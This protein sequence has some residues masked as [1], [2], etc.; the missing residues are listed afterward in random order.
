L[1]EYRREVAPARWATVQHS[2]GAL[3]YRRYE[4][5]GAEEHA[6]A[7]ARHYRDA[8]EVR[9]REVAPADWATVQHSLGTLFYRRYERSG[10]QEHAQ[11]AARHYSSVL[12]QAKQAPLAEIYPF[13]A[14]A[15]LLRI[16]F[17]Q[18]RWAEIKQTHQH[19]KSALDV[20]VSTQFFRGGKETWLREAQGLF[21]LAAYAHAKLGDKEK[22]VEIIES[23]RAQLLREALEQNR[24]DLARL[25]ELGF[26]TLYNSYDQARRKYSSL[27]AL[28]EGQERP[29]SWTE[30]TETARK[31]LETAVEAIRE[32]KELR[33]KLPAFEHFMRSLP[34]EEI[35]KLIPD[36]P[37]VYLLST[38]EGGLA[39]I[40]DDKNIHVEWM[41]DLSQD[42]LE[43]HIWTSGEPPGGYLGQYAQWQRA[44]FDQE[45]SEK[46]LKAL[47][48]NWLDTIE[49]TTQW[50]WDACMGNLVDLLA[51]QH[52]CR[53][54]LIPTGQLS[55]LPLHA[56]WVQDSDAP[57]GRRYALDEAL[58]T[59][60]P[61]AHALYVAE[62]LV[63]EADSESV[64]AVD[65]PDGSL[66]FSEDEVRAV[67]AGFE[68]S[69]HLQGEDATVERV[70]TQLAQFDVLH[71]STHGIAGW[72]QPLQ[73]HLTMADGDLT[74]KEI[75]DLQLPGSRLAVLS[76]CESGVI[77]TDLPNEVVSLPSGLQQ[78][79]VAGVAGSMWT[80]LQ[81]S[82]AIL[83]ARF[84]ELWREEDFA[85]P[86]ALRQAQIWLR[87][88]TDGQ[89]KAFFRK[90]MVEYAS[91][92][93]PSE[94]ADIFFKEI[95][96]SD[97]DERSFAHPFHWAAFNYTGI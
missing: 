90:D 93:L 71:F 96:F 42:Q 40:V 76:A 4:R 89:K 36:K 72:A 34:Y 32:N 9:R 18:H 73:S 69:E 29:P 2:L 6:Q 31:A 47:T 12:E 38:S 82:T 77:G 81:V 86:E 45:T 60:A 97:S 50:L 67:L 19:V 26:K 70:K 92:K 95:Y 23:G 44:L 16:R 54:I 10:A 41:N 79:G 83:M 46:R 75:L 14:G 25:P 1:E 43:N 35:Q 20:L 78:A 80:V 21:G 49:D 11:A 22:A 59:Y 64:L 27:L 94:S 33:E 48:Q 37:L 8:L 52:H 24:R 88:S 5:S 51:A 62:Q 53:A 63:D 65:N 57:T 87:D 84:Y 68:E 74:L 13:R 39:L 56:A 30:K 91:P 28:T 58:L 66:R 85:P 3:F 61:S 7:A 55:L 17:R 15:S